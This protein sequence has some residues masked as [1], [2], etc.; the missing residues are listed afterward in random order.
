MKQGTNKR[1]IIVGIKL[2]TLVFI[3]SSVFSCARDPENGKA[4]GGVDVG[5]MSSTAASIPGTNVTITIPRTWDFVTDGKVL[6][7][8]KAGSSRI[9]ASRSELT[10][11]SSPSQTS[12]ELY[13]ESIY[14]NRDYKR[15]ELNGMKGVGAEYSN[16]KGDLE[17][18]M[19]LISELKDFIHIVGRY[20]KQTNDSVEGAQIIS[21]VKIEYKGS[22]VEN[23]SPKTVDLKSERKPKTESDTFTTFKAWT[24]YSLLDECET[25]HTVVSSAS[26]TC[27]GVSLGIAF[28]KSDNG[29]VPGLYVGGDSRIIELGPAD[30]IPFDLIFVDDKY[31]YSPESKI[32]ISDVYSV[33]TPDDQH[34]ESRQLVPKPDHIYLVRTI[35]WPFEDLIVKIKVNSIESGKSLN[36]T[37]QKLVAVNAD[38]LQEQVDLINKNT[39]ENE[40]P[41]TEGEVTLFNNTIWKN[42]PYASFNFKYSTSGNKYITKD[43]WHFLFRSCSVSN[44]QKNMKPVL[45]LSG[46]NGAIFSLGKKPLQEIAK[47][48]FPGSDANSNRCGM[49]VEVGNTYGVYHLTPNEAAYGAVQIVD[50]AKDGSWVR[51]NFKRV[52]LGYPKRNQNW[53]SLP[54]LWENFTTQVKSGKG[55]SFFGTTRIVFDSND[56]V[57]KLIF[58]NTSQFKSINGFFNFGNI[59]NID[60]ITYEEILKNEKYFIQELVVKESDVVGIYSEDFENKL[61]AMISIDKHKQGE[62]ITLTV[63]FLYQGAVPYKLNFYL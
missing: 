33:F 38:I 40:M 14:P 15:V 42:T 10:D 17:S 31:L 11:L 26:K 46:S 58:K 32:P 19:Y 23:A 49:Q 18:D 2:I 62:S 39:I 37:Y 8:T 9:E 21:T 43:N 5:N 52:D 59:V 20:P 48:D 4:Q 61:I 36:L 27:K 13:L 22:K 6:K 35:N 53:V 45:T 3:L 41:L 55:V 30:K 29:L 47:S 54:K 34:V 12:L 25:D 63:K 51:L 16:N 50:M 28:W 7:I 60:S 57:D 1:S 44:D 24:S 56:K